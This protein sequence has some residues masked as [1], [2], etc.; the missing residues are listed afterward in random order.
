M[1]RQRMSWAGVRT[2]VE[3]AGGT[4]GDEVLGR[5]RQLFL[6][7]SH[8]ITTNAL[9]SPVRTFFALLCWSSHYFLCQACVAAACVE[10]LQVTLGAWC[11]E[12]AVVDGNVEVRVC[13]AAWGHDMRREKELRRGDV[14]DSVKHSRADE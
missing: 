13:E 10:R 3:K 4:I 8:I 7:L 6:I 12:A 9:L 14:W 2:A 1:F 5:M 11:K